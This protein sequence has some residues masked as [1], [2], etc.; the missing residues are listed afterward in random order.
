MS[1]PNVDLLWSKVRDPKI[2]TLIGALGIELTHIGSDGVRG[3]MPVDGR[4]VQYFGQLHGGASVALAETLSS[5][6]ACV[7]IDLQKEAAVGL[8]INANHV[9]AAS[10]GRVHGEAKP[11]H[12]G[13][14][15]QIWAIE[16][17]NEEGKLICTSRCTMA[18]VSRA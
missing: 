3:T 15:T 14:R 11:V 12:L 13:K 5:I 6:G 8:E 17:K 16:I 9:R 2:Q 4:T 1:Q 18:V 7:H 10:S